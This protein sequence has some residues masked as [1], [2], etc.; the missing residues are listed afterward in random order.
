MGQ[1]VEGV[2]EQEDLGRRVKG[3][4][5]VRPD[6]SFRN[7]ITP[8]GSPGPTGDGGF[9]AEKDRYHLYISYACPWA[10]RALIVRRLKNLEGAIGLSVTN[11]FMGDD[12]WTFLGGEPGATTDE[13]SGKRYAHELYT[14]AKADY[15][16]RVTVPI[17]WDKRNKTIVNNESADIIRIFNQAFD[18]L[19]GGIGNPELD[20][21]PESLRAEIDEV[22]ELVYHAINNGVY[23][24][25]FGGGTDQKVYDENCDALFDAL[26][27]MEDRLRGQRYLIGSA[28]TE[29][30][31]RLFVTLVRFDPV[32]VTHF[33]C[34]KKRISDYPNLSNYMRDLYRVPGVAETVNLDHIR[35]HYYRSMRFLNPGGVVAAGFDPELDQPH[36]RDRF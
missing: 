26:D 17:L 20:L 12:G 15:T 10:H 14:A 27:Q 34:N 11:S 35:S 33:K 2:W 30:D 22:N 3:G 1:L 21:Y 23:K 8:D 31:W 16:G 28:T 4:R 9:A 32:Y 18:H 5:F 6:S 7:W 29:A 25:G 19:G 24:T 36:D 13:V